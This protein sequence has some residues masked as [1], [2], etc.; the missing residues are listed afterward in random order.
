MCM[1]Q[2]CLCIPATFP[3]ETDTHK[4]CHAHTVSNTSSLL[5]N[6]HIQ[7]RNKGFEVI[8]SINAEREIL[9]HLTCKHLKL[10]KCL[11]DEALWL[12]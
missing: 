6:M 9:I 11:T 10:L 8:W 12:V 1:V 2:S 5:G 3:Y 7:Q 4:C